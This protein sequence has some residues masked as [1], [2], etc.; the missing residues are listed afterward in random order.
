MSD[1][2]VD[3]FMAIYIVKVVSI[4]NAVKNEDTSRGL[5]S[6][7]EVPKPIVGLR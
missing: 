6:E 2:S 1:L 7:G 5:T 4:D 3:K